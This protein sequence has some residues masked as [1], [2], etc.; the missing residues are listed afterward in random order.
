MI[1]ADENHSYVLAKFSP[2]G[3][4]IAYV[5]NSNTGTEDLSSLWVMNVDGSDKRKLD[6]HMVPSVIFYDWGP[7]GR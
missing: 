3:S 2:D 6:G 4:K 7:K 1:E 5:C